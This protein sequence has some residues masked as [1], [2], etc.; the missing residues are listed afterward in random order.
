MEM[1]LKFRVDLVEFSFK[2]G[3]G[4]AEAV[5]NPPGPREVF[6]LAFDTPGCR[7]AGEDGSQV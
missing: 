6:A 3:I 5:H 7:W 1:V 4:V 2:N